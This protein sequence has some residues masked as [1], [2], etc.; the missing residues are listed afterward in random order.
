[1]T[2]HD[3][4][5]TAV[6]PTATGNFSSCSGSVDAGADP[7]ACTG[8][9][10]STGSFLVD[11]IDNSGIKSNYTGTVIGATVTGTFVVPTLDI[12]GTFSCTR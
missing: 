4:V 11:T 12:S 7:F 6:L 9:I 3:G 10:S 5:F 8:S 2:G 1:M